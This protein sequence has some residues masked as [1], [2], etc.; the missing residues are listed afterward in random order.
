MARYSV[1]FLLV[2]LCCATNSFAAV[3]TY[4]WQQELEMKLDEKINK[5]E[6]R[7]LQLEEKVNQLEN[8]LEN[9]LENKLENQ[10]EN[11]RL[12]NVSLS[13]L[14]SSFLIIFGLLLGIRMILAF[15]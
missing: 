11:Q 14:F 15:R 13:F 1:V 4:K 3:T 8:K 5:L 9:Q 6:A 2:I 12:V 7:N 10:L